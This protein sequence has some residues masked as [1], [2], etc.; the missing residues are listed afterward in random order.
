LYLT[1]HEFKAVVLGHIFFEEAVL[2][3]CNP[4]PF[5]GADGGAER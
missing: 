1:D 4:E 5:G 3:I 2:F